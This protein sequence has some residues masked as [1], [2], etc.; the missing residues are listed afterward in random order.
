MENID[1]LFSYLLHLNR[2][3]SFASWPTI[4][5]TAPAAAF[6]NTISPAFG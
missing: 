3:R 5:P 2:T 6:T 4:L 1:T